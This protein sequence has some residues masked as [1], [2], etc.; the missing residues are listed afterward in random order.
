MIFITTRCRGI[1]LDT[2]SFFEELMDVDILI[3]LIYRRTAL[4]T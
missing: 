1:G 3:L 4:R 2:V